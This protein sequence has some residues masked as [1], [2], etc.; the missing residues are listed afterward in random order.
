MFHMHFL[1]L[2]VAS[3]GSCSQGVDAVKYLSEQLPGHG[4]LRHLEDRPSGMV[5]DPCSYLDQFDLDTA[6]RPVGYLAGKGKAP[7][8]VAEVVG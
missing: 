4:H 8:E 1:S 2:S 7:E 3:G 6:K 5:Y